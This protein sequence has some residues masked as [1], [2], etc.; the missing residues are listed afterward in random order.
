MTINKNTEGSKLIIALEGRLDTTTAPELEAC[1]KDSL[2][3]VKELVLNL[4]KLEYISSAG[5][6]ILL[7]AQKM[8]NQQGTMVVTGANSIVMEVFEVTGFTDILTLA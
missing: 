6:R 3:D 4:E 5:L 8:M 1:I 2:Q 7:L